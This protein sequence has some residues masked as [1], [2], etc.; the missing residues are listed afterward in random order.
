MASLNELL[1]ASAARH[2]HLCPRQVLGVRMGL[3]AGEVLGIPIPQTDK[4]LLAIV[5]T[6]GCASDGVAVATNCWVGRRTLWVEDYGKVA[7]TFVDTQ[8]GQ[9]IRIAPRASIRD[10]VLTYAPDCESKWEAQLLGYQR[11]PACEL[12]AVQAVQLKT[13]LAWLVSKPG[14]KV[15]CDACGEEIMNEREIVHDGQI[16]CRACAGRGYYDTFEPVVLKEPELQCL[17]LI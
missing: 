13:P 12:L 15:I 6:N 3:L 11:M 10:S 9:A 4:R 14:L 16:L 2:D 17:S 7:A 5:E 8:S 1:E